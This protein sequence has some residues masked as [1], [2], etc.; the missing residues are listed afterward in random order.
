MKSR[1]SWA[2]MSFA[3]WESCEERGIQ[4]SHKSWCLVRRGGHSSLPLHVL[5]PHPDVRKPGLPCFLPIG[6]G[7]ATLHPALRFPAP[8]PVLFPCSPAWVNFYTHWCISHHP[9][10]YI[11]LCQDIMSC[12][13][14][15]DSQGE[16]PLLERPN[17]SHRPSMAA[18]V[19][20]TPGDLCIS[21]VLMPH[22][23]LWT[24][25]PSVLYEGWPCRQG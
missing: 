21:P 2:C 7:K 20:P 8:G 23:W 25:S 19:A 11:V 4:P 9:H 15:S 12:F 14:N 6:L 3:G 1:K 13:R 17:P 10:A 22:P 5:R 24:Q 18:S 16:E